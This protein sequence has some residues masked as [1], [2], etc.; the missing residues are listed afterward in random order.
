MLNRTLARLRNLKRE[1]TRLGWRWTIYYR[2]LKRLGVRELKLRAKGISTPVYC[3]IADSDI[4]EF[5]QS[6]GK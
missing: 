5:N 1:A 4:Y 3:R 6:L 2:I